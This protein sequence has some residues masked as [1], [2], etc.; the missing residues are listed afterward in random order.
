[1]GKHSCVQSCS[2]KISSRGQSATDTVVHV[3]VLDRMEPLRPVVDG[4]LLK[5]LMKEILT[6]GDFTIPKEGFCRLNPQLAR[7]IVGNSIS[8]LS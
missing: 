8:M 6:P 7:K 2:R 3:R 5:L 4:V 1:M